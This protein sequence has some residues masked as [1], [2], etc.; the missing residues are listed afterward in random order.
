MGNLEIY[1]LLMLA[2]FAGWLLGKLGNRSK[3][4]TEDGLGSIFHDYFVGLNYLLNDEPDEAIDTFYQ[5]TRNK[6]RDNRDPPC[7]RGTVEAPG[8]GG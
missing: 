4:Q 1:G 8:Q 5:S 6:Q 3:K 7:A 2:I